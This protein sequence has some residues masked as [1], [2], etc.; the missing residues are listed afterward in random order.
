MTPFYQS[1]KQRC[2]NNGE[3]KGELLT[4][5]FENPIVEFISAGINQQ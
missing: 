5:I 4:H 1:L 3:Q 2:K